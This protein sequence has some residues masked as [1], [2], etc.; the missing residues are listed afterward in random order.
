M[1]GI[2][3]GPE[4]FVESEQREPEERPAKAVE[5]EAE[6][7]SA[8]ERLEGG[9]GEPKDHEG[10]LNRHQPAPE[11]RPGSGKIQGLMNGSTERLAGERA[12]QLRIEEQG[13]GVGGEGGTDQQND[14]Q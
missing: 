8:D 4:A 1:E 14:E 10:R 6:R 7:E 5:H 2:G 11:E 12:A 13:L 3:E 9:T